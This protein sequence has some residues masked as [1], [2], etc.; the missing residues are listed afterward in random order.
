VVGQL[1]EA[2]IAEESRGALV[3]F[4]KKPDGSDEL[5]PMIVRKSDGGYGYATTDIAAMLYRTERWQPVRIIII[6]DERQQLHFKQLLRVSAR[7]GIT[8]F[9]HV[10][11]GLMRLPEGTISTRG[12]TLISLEALL[13]EAERRAYDVAKS[14][15]EDL[16]E[17]ELRKVARVVGLGAVKYND[18]SK[19]RQ[20]LV[21]F[22]WDKALAL[23]GNTAPYLQYAYARIQSIL[24][25]AETQPGAV[26]ALS[27]IER[28]LVKR[29]LWFPTV[30]EQVAA[31]LRPHQLCDYLYELANTF[32]TF[33]N[34]M[35]VIKAETN[36]LR[37]SRLALCALTARTLETGLGLLGIEVLDRM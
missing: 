8:N 30:I 24:R 18:L 6:T 10:W 11:F 5:T 23:N 17:A 21:S 20:T 31:S 7:L 22:T 16:S 26:A 3:V 4:F 29:L 33:Y 35:P 12:G 25:K 34:E 19:D 32:S 13:D 36:E 37:D 14:Q 1:A 9:E 15:R 2:G 28:D 27:P